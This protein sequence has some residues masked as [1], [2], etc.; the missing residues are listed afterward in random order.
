M[1]SHLLCAFYVLGTPLSSRD[2]GQWLVETE[3]FGHDIGYPPTHVSAD[4]RAKTSAFRPQTT[5]TWKRKREVI[6]SESE[7][8]SLL[9][10]VLWAAEP[11]WKRIDE[12]V[13]W[14]CGLQVACLWNYSSTMYCREI[15]DYVAPGAGRSLRELAHESLRACLRYFRP[16]YG[17]A[18]VLPRDWRPNAYGLGLPMGGMPA[19]LRCDAND[20]F[21]IR[22]GECDR[23]VRN[24]F[25]LSVLSGGHMELK[26][27]DQPLAEWVSSAEHRG[28][29][30]PFD[31]GL[32]LWTFEG[33][34]EG[35]EFLRWDH[36]AV[37]QTRQELM[38]RQFFPWQEDLAGQMEIEAEMEEMDS[39]C[40]V[41]CLGGADTAMGCAAAEVEGEMEAELRPEGEDTIQNLDSVDMVVK[42]AD[43]GVRLIVV[44][45]RGLDDRLRTQLRLIEKVENYAKYIKSRRFQR[46]FGRATL[47]KTWIVIESAGPIS[48]ES[49]KTIEDLRR[50]LEKK[51][52]R[53]VVGEGL[54]EEERPEG[55]TG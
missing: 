36:G 22:K 37:S 43:G 51:G 42:M 38:E 24:V 25:G 20:W 40:A 45:S 2:I 11:K 53:L 3:R 18:A 46:E 10:A 19:L 21:M 13:R 5:Y 52:I 50:R 31:E 33:L 4:I 17:F 27:D 16:A 55:E 9:D 48:E 1:I 32:W 47:E 15:A 12:D 28:R 35:D 30:E 7:T 39:D 44:A 26:V 14:C 49:Y 8:G 6:L 29:I 34:G 41:V 23:V 54:S